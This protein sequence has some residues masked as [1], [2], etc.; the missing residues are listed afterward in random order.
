MALQEVRNL[1]SNQDDVQGTE[2]EDVVEL[3]DGWD[4]G[5]QPGP[6]ARTDM[7]EAEDEPRPPPPRNARAGSRRQLERRSSCTTSLTS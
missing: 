6:T 7:L 4:D 1:V 2:A 3:A 5:D